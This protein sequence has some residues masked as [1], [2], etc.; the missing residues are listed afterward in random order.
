[1]KNYFVVMHALT[2]PALGYLKEYRTSNHGLYLIETDT[3]SPNNTPNWFEA[4]LWNPQIWFHL[5][6]AQKANH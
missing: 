2:Y 1:M 3:L 4:V 5:P 6:N